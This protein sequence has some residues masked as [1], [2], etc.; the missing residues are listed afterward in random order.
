MIPCAVKEMKTILYITMLVRDLVRKVISLVTQL[1]AKSL[2]MTRGLLPKFY[3]RWAS[4]ETF[5][6]LLYY[7][8]TIFNQNLGFS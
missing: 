5:G 8:C 6:L 7:A 1:P 2:V 4:A 3:D